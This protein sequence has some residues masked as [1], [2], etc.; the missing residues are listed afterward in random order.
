MKFTFGTI[1]L[2][3]ILKMLSLRI[4][5][6]KV[7]SFDFLVKIIAKSNIYNT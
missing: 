5:I 7:I 6:T 2:I 3:L 1:I 4:K